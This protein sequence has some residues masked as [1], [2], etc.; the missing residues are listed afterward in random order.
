MRRR[1]EATEDHL[2]AGWVV[3]SSPKF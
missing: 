3:R 1:N 2:K